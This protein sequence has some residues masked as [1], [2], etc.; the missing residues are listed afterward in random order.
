[1]LL[2]Y[3]WGRS[4]QPYPATG[5]AYQRRGRGRRKNNPNGELAA[6]LADLKKSEA[7]KASQATEIR[8]CLE[9]LN[10]TQGDILKRLRTLPASPAGGDDTWGKRMA[11]A[12]SPQASP[13]RSAPTQAR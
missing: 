11:W 1:M 7:L 3:T 6:H 8:K 12:Q 9:Q 2:R 13:A 5:H 4:V 10:A